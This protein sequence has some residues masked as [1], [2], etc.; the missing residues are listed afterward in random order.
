LQYQLNPPPTEILQRIKFADSKV[1]TLMT[2]FA[3]IIWIFPLLLAAIG[4]TGVAQDSTTPKPVLQTIAEVDGAVLSKRL[5]KGDNV[6]YLQ[7]ID[8]RKMHI[9]QFVEETSRKG[10]K[11]GKYYQGEG[12]FPSPYFKM[13]TVAEVQKQYQTQYG[14]SVFSLLNG[15]FFEDYQASS[16]LSFPIKINGKIITGGS[17][18][19]GPIRKPADPHYKTVRL[20]TLVWDDQKVSIVDYT[21]STGAPLNQGVVKNA[22]VSYQYQDH[23]AYVFNPKAVNR[24]Y[25]LGTL[26]QDRQA[27]DE[28]LVILTMI[29]G[30]LAESAQ[31]LREFGVKSEILT[32]DGGSST[33]LF[34]PQAGAI[35]LPQP[36]Q[37]DGDPNLRKLPHYIGVRLKPKP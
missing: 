15:A 26:D 6:A 18:P 32:L 10:E 3:Q 22:I 27:G 35:S 19:Y 17:S 12:K 23:P 29:R 5:L 31:V 24:Y 33:Y 4:C 14:A 36:A 21:T 30:T 37:D 9:D 25:L 8:V 7:V 11:Q 2:Q 16:R 28:S 1:C 13:K 20:K 34:N